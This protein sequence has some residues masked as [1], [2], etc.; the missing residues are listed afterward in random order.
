MLVG[1]LGGVQQH[2]EG[3]APSYTL[4]GNIMFVFSESILG[5]LSNQ[6]ENETINFL[7]NRLLTLKP[8][9]QR[10]KKRADSKRQIDCTHT[11]RP[12]ANR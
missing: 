12:L 4:L 2:V 10:Q 9:F 7:E 11:L 3:S 5:K 6:T 8:A 1:S